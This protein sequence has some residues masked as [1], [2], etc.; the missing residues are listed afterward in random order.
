MN[1]KADINRLVGRAPETGFS[2]QS[3]MEM[4]PQFSYTELESK[5]N[6]QNISIL[7]ARNNMRIREL[8][9]DETRSYF[10]PSLSLY[11]DYGYTRNGYNPGTI[12]WTESM[13]PTVGLR[14]GFNI[15][16][17][18]NDRRRREIS[19]IQYE[20]AQFEEKD[21]LIAAKSELYQ[22]YNTYTSAIKQIDLE[23]KNLENARKNLQ[24]AVELYKRGAINE[25]EFR[26]IQRKEFDAENRLLYAQYYAKTAE[27][28]LLQ[29]SG[30]LKIEANN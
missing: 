16:N 21:Q 11:A 7:L 23:T 15:F 6:N 13:G 18:F 3:E 19:K 12:D 17:G 2:A 8:E 26:E 20:S 4:L 28:Q 25:I 10:L 22:S 24:F 27:I 29:I 5:L 1:L 30:N 9:M 14:L